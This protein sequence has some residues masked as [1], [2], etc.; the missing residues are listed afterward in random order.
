MQAKF[1]PNI[2]FEETGDANSWWRD[3]STA[4]S[5][6][7]PQIMEPYYP[8]LCRPLEEKLLYFQLYL[9]CAALTLV[10]G[11]IHRSTIEFNQGNTTKNRAPA[12]PN[13]PPSPSQPE[14]AGAQTHWSK[15]TP[16]RFAKQAPQRPPYDAQRMVPRSKCIILHGLLEIWADKVAQETFCWR[17]SRGSTPR[18]IVILKTQRLGPRRANPPTSPRPL[19]VVVSDQ[20]VR[21]LLMK[22]L[23][24]LCNLYPQVYFHFD[25][26]IK[27]REKLAEACQEL[28]ARR[29]KGER[30]L[31]IQGHV[32]VK[33]QLLYQWHDNSLS[34]SQPPTPPPT[35]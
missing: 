16:K 25:R 7:E 17:Q 15:V 20:A 12:S 32:V 21:D 31:T 14:S 6:I 35:R 8:K 33:I 5:V 28:N 34:M 18:T 4:W 1:R 2:F 23:F 10:C 30:G 26:P 24:Q 13:N 29:E 27:E 3:Y 19:M 22:S 11:Q 9:Q